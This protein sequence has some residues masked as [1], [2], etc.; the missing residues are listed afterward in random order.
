MLLLSPADSFKINFLKNSF[1]NTIRGLNSF[2][3]DQAQQKVGPDLGSNCLQRLSA[4]NKMCGW[5]G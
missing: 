5:A 4:D 1:R 3:P 2:D